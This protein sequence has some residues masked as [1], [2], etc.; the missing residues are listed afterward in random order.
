MIGRRSDAKKPAQ[1]CQPELREQSVGAAAVKEQSATTMDISTLPPRQ[2]LAQA[3][4]G[5]LEVSKEALSAL[6]DG[7]VLETHD[8]GQSV[9]QRMDELLEMTFSPGAKDMFDPAAALDLAERLGRLHHGQQTELRRTV[10]LLDRIT[11]PVR[12]KVTVKAAGQ[13][14]NIAS[15]QQV[16]SP[17]DWGGQ[18]SGR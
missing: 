8:R 15:A 4:E 16:A 9:G 17:V 18:E 7:L 2:A 6:L 12:S 11:R 10:E 14:V 13:Q 5:K 3:A 1:S